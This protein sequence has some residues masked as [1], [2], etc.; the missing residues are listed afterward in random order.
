MQA[1]HT[2]ASWPFGCSMD[3]SDL[4]SLVRI[5]QTAAHFLHAEH[6][7]GT[8]LRDAPLWAWRTDRPYWARAWRMGP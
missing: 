2:T 4:A 7:D 6:V 3:D 5:A 1:M 8:S